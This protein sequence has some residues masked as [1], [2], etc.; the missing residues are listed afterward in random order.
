MT[1]YSQA[2][3]TDFSG[4]CM[5]WRN[6][7]K[8]GLGNGAAGSCLASPSS[9]KSL[10]SG[11]EGPPPAAYCIFPSAWL[12]ME[13]LHYWV[14]SSRPQGLMPVQYLVTAAEP[15]LLLETTWHPNWAL[16]RLL[17]WYQ[18]LL[19]FHFFK[20]LASTCLVP[21]FLWPPITGLAHFPENI[22]HGK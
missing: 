18:P 2:L 13:Q 11:A 4:F 5:N 10:F 17:R 3:R 1:S 15:S 14:S 20:P 9:Y 19:S 16:T 22:C 21:I 7:S 6:A 12:R 8:Q